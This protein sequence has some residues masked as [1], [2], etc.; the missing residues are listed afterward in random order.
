[1]YVRLWK[2]EGATR[3]GAIVPDKES[4]NKEIQIHHAE[5][6]TLKPEDL[7]TYAL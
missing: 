1:M 7:L 5:Q 4:K 2:G 3:K 6:A